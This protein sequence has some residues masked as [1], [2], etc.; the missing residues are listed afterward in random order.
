MSAVTLRLGLLAVRYDPSAGSTTALPP[1]RGLGRLSLQDTCLSTP[2]EPT[3][4]QVTMLLFLSNIP[5]F[6]DFFTG[7]IVKVALAR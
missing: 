4:A 1:L 6:C 5:K 7:R 2:R 3:L